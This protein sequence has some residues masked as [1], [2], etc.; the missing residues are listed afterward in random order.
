MARDPRIQRHAGQ[1]HACS[2][3][4]C[5]RSPPPPARAPTAA[6]GGRR[7]RRLRQRGAPGPAADH[8]DAVQRSR[9]GSL[10]A[11]HVGG[12]GRA[13]RPGPAASAAAPAASSAS[14][15]P[16]RQPLG[17]G[18]RDHRGVVGAVGERRRQEG[19][20]LRVARSPAAARAP[21][22]WPPRRRRRRTAGRGRRARRVAPH[23]PDRAVRQL[24]ARSRP[25]RPRRR[26]ARSCS[27]LRALG[28][29]RGGGLQAG[30][31]EVAALAARPASAASGS[32]RRRRRSASASS[33]GPPG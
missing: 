12:R 20:A 25:A 7:A 32:A 8:A 10:A 22:R 5:G 4:R 29:P 14:T 15:R 6:P 26:R 24:A 19:E 18:E 13:P 3:A 2:R 9:L 27:S 1:E 16:A 21:R 33:A 30:E 17:A 31:G 11:R 28:Q 23:R